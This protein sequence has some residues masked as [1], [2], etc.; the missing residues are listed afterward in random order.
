[1]A[2]PGA[3]TLD[4]LEIYNSDSVIPLM[5]KFK[6]GVNV[7]Q[8]EGSEQTLEIIESLISGGA[9]A[10]DYHFKARCTAGGEKLLIEAGKDRPFLSLTPV[11]RRLCLFDARAKYDWSRE[12]YNYLNDEDVYSYNN[13]LSRQTCGISSTQSFRVYFN[14][15]IDRLTATNTLK[16]NGVFR[17][18][19]G[20]TPMQ[21]NFDCYANVLAFWDGFNEIRD[22]NHIRLPIIVIGK[23]IDTDTVKNRQIILIKI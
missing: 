11:E 19:S 15:Y 1:M 23:D 18:H 4:R 7:I 2:I 22:F 8:G 20:A 6:K 16:E 17:R 3:M 21:F 13:R 14:R 9:F 12:F 10:S 5:M